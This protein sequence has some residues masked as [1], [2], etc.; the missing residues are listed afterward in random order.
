MIGQRFIEEIKTL[1]ELVRLIELSFDGNHLAPPA[2]IK[3]AEKLK[4]EKVSS[5]FGE[6]VYR[7]KVSLDGHVG[8]YEDL[9]KMLIAI[10]EELIKRIASKGEDR[11]K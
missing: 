6:Y 7:L 9:D 8:A 5:S 10:A 2:I 1:N 3:M 4:K 11:S